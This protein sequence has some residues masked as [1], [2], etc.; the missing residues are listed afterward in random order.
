M[1]EGWSMSVSRK[2][3]KS[4]LFTALVEQAGLKLQGERGPVDFIVIDRAEHPTED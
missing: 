4:H 2:P 1:A 3:P